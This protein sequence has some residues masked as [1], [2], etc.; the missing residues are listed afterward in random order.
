MP[1]PSTPCGQATTE[2]ALQPFLG[3]PARRAA[4]CGHILRSWIPY[5]VRAWFN[6]PVGDRLTSA[7]QATPETAV[8][9]V[10]VM[11]V[12]YV[13]TGA[14]HTLPLYALQV[15]SYLMATCRLDAHGTNLIF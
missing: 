2:T 4:A 8:R 6:L 15:G 1:D 9:G 14:C 11:G 7:K 5:A 3:W 13:I 10:A 12:Q